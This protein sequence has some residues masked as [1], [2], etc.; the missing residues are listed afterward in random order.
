[1]QVYIHVHEQTQ[2]Y[3]CTYTYEETADDMHGVQQVASQNEG[4]VDS[5][6]RE[7]SE[8]ERVEGQETESEVAADIC[9][10]R[11]RRGYS[12]SSRIMQKRPRALACRH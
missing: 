3:A 10:T 6:V 2:V 1:M 5:W 9:G 8:S 12:N 11:L 4:E 7:G